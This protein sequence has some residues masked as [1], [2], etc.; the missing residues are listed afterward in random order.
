MQVGPTLRA[1]L[2]LA[3]LAALAACQGADD[4]SLAER[5]ELANTS[6]LAVVPKTPPQLLLRGFETHCLT[7]SDTAGAR[8]ARLR[9]AGYVPAGGWRGDSRDFV[10]GDRRPKV[11]ITRNG[12]G[13][14]VIAR[15]RTGQEAAV[16]AALPGWFPQAAAVRSTDRN[17][18]WQTGRSEGEGF[19]ILRSAA[20]PHQNEIML[21]LIQL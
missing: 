12:R 6:M 11:R 18:I 3:L 1:G 5:Q 19:A 9:A 17:R 20:G 14:A 21:A 15:A 7:P 16:Q 4:S 2:P 10:T 13:C 8:S